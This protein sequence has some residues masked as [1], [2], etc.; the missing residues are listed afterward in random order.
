MPKVV[1][2]TEAGDERVF[3]LEDKV[4]LNV[5]ESRQFEVLSILNVLGSTSLS[6]LLN[7]LIHTKPFRNLS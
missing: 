2:N 5:F 7:Q 3:D 4:D 6:N 1:H